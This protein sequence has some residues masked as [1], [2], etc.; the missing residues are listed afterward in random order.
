MKKMIPIY[1]LLIAILGV[2]VFQLRETQAL[3]EELAGIRKEQVRRPASG[4]P[5][6]P[7]AGL[8]VYITNEPLKV[9]SER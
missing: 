4:G 9:S 1:F 6:P 5:V 8:P 2:F 3:R 7:G